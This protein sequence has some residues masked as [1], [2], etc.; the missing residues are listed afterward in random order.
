[1]AK[2]PGLPDIP[3]ERR[4]PEI[5]Q[6]LEVLRYQMEVIQGLRDEIAVLK[7]QKPRPKIRPGKMDKNAGSSK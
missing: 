5:V 4:S 3:E 6:L 7:G 1:M 2:I